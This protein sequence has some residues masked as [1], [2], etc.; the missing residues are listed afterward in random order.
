M[1]TGEKN[2]TTSASR[3]KPSSEV[4]KL[5]QQKKAL[6]VNLDELLAAQKEAQEALR[7]VEACQQKAD[8]ILSLVRESVIVADG[9][10]NVMFL[11]QAAEHLFGLSSAEM[12][13]QP[14]KTLLPTLEVTEV[15]TTEMTLTRRDEST[16]WADVQ[17]RSIQV[18]EVNNYVI[19][20]RDNSEEK[21]VR[22][23]AD[24]M[25]SAVD[26]GFAT[27]EFMPDGTILKANGNFLGALGYTNANDVVGQH[28]R[29]FC[30]P[31]Y[32]ASAEYESHW[33]KLRQGDIVS[34]EFRRKTKNGHDLWINAAY[35]PVVDA[36]GTVVKIIKIATDITAMVNARKQGEH[37]QAAV[38]T[39]WAYVE[40]EANGTIVAANDNFLTVMGYP[41]ASDITGQ[42]HR[43]FCE[44]AYANSSDYAAFWTNLSTGNIQKGEY[45]RVRKDG[46]PVWLQA[47]Y[48]PIKN[49]EGVV[50]KVVKIAADVSDIKFPVLAVSEIISGMAQGNLTQRFNVSADG[51]VQEMGDAL[52][53]AIENLNALL[54]SIEK[55]ANFVAESSASVLEKSE[56]ATNSTSEVSTAIAEMARG[57]QDQA[58]K[59][60]ESSKLVE[61]VKTSGSDMEN[62]ANSIYQTAEKGQKSCE[63]G[64]K[65]VKNLVSNMQG[66]SES[67]SLTSELIGILTQRAEEIG[68]TLN[69]ITDIA[70]QTNLLA[71]N[72]AIEAARAGDAGRG[73]AVV[74]E[75]IR[76][77][78]ED[79]RRSAIDIEKIIADVQKD[80]QSAGRAI[81]TMAGSVKEG[82]TAT[83]AASTIFEEI[84]QASND[85]LTYSREIQEATLEQKS[86]VELVARNIEQIVVVAEETAAGAEEVASSSHEL[87]NSMRD[88]TQANN[89]L[90]D[91]ADELQQGINQFKLR[92]EQ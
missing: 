30:D 79:S 28:H 54:S 52:N 16:F 80:T 56:S 25:Q 66:V 73:F 60:D 21:K 55:N 20:V 72:A 13:G 34:G 47:A 5:K 36:N 69:V 84:A 17:V 64:L 62:K 10:K 51:Y 49:E 81:D 70:A 71:L 27:V 32:V 33:N 1:K 18:A 31:A 24:Q 26:A 75:E 35:T 74:A 12:I 61:L 2:T 7:Q 85:T 90:S 11:N 77:L 50:I 42:H 91:I 57:A 87:N 65:I 43:I 67:A 6:E 4:E 19:L 46:R 86:S 45:L 53:V 37:T 38:D 39:G 48:T 63:D 23:R 83:Q 82:S 3:K 92:K 8:Q 41:H 15:E 88:I 68:R 40:F 29:L 9:E 78:A 59:T 14:V 58:M 76:K 44:A 89:K 22:D